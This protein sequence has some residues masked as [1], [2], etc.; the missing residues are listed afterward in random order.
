M[1]FL[2]TT[3]AA[4][5]AGQPDLTSLPAQPTRS[6]AGAGDDQRARFEADAIPY[7]RPL[8]PAALRLTR[9]HCDAEDLIQE[10]FAKAY[11]AFHQF[12]PGTNLKAWL[13]RILVTTFYSACRKREREPV[14]VLAAEVRD[15]MDCHDRLSQSPRS[16]ELEALDHLVDSGV[17]RA[18]GELPDCY[19]AAVYLADVQGYRYSEI[20]DLLGT[21]LGTV[22]SRIH[23]GRQLLRYKLRGAGVTDRAI[24]LPSGGERRRP[25]RR[26][27]RPV[28]ITAPATR[29][30]VPAPAGT[31]L[32]A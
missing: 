32:A 12:T 21:P 15:P 26:P 31:P 17:M 28:T 27:V 20:A 3:Q 23:R 30:P 25:G 18:L 2:P 5:H 22:M 19:K 11:L 8:Y 16:A 24:P 9:N 1:N 7:M 29:R 14:Q 10:T 4:D 13:H 6:D